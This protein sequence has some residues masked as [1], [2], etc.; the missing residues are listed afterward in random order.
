V[1]E[2]LP[3]SALIVGGLVL[4]GFAGLIF[5]DLRHQS[6]GT[7]PRFFLYL[8]RIQLEQAER[9]RQLWQAL[10][11]LDRRTLPVGDGRRVTIESEE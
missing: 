2:L 10:A 1:L 8:E 5:W 6:T 11:Q 3:F 4:A 7:D 9:D